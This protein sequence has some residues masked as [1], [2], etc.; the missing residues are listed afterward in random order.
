VELL[1]I[2][3]IATLFL[4]AC[5]GAQS[6]LAPAPEA[7]GQL[8]IAPVQ[9]NWPAG[10]PQDGVQPWETAGAD[11]LVVPSDRN[12]STIN[13]DAEYVTGIDVFTTGGTTAN[14]G[15]VLAIDSGTAGS[16]DTSFAIYRFVMGGQAPGALGVDLNLRNRSDGNPSEYYIGLADYSAEAW[17][18]HG[19]FTDGVR[20]GMTGGMLSGLATRS[21]RWWRMTADFDVAGWGSIR[22][23]AATRM[24]RRRPTRRAS[25]RSTAGC[26]WSGCR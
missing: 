5:G 6:A 22:R 18:W 11:G 15:G 19:P 10:L 24:L 12:A 3:I 1:V 20:P 17:Q 21:W 4:S 2:L 14:A 26:C 8:D 25:R 13:L 23:T 16:G 9:A 7:A